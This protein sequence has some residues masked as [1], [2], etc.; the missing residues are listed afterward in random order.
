[1]RVIGLTGSIGTGKSQVSRILRELGAPVIDAD[2]LTHDLQQRGQALWQ[3]VRRHYG[4]SILGPNGQILRRKLGRR[5]FRD[6]AQRQDLNGL[7]H[8]VVRQHIAQR[9]AELSQ[10]GY[11]VVVLDIPL[12]IEGHWHEVVDEIWVVY[13]PMHLQ[14]QRVIRRDRLGE[15]EALRRIR[16]QMPIDEKIRYADHII[17]NQGSLDLLTEQVTRLWHNLNITE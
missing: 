4:W 6:P 16:S 5:I 15:A 3:A 10:Q 9:V 17:D 2:A 14:L 8:P 1:M 7:V 11:P 12:L 13:A